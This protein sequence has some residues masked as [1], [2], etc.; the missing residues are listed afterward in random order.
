LELDA[1]QSIDSTGVAVLVHLHK[2]LRSAGNHLVLLAPSRS[3]KRA[4][5]A[6]RLDKILEVAAD[7]LEARDVIAACSGQ[8]MEPVA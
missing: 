8:L 7:A 1:T 3:V 6:M 2:Q 5:A 4:L